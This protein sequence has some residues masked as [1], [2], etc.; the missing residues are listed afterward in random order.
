[1][2]RKP[3]VK[4][5]IACRS[6]T[7]LVNLLRRY[8]IKG[9]RGSETACALAQYAKA[10]GFEYPVVRRDGICRDEKTMTW[11]WRPSKVRERFVTRFDL[12]CYPDLCR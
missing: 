12:G 4:A 9:R 1:M 3:T 11:V 10:A 8:K 2:K 6:L 7:A 5:L